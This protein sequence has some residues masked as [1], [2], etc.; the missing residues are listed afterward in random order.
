VAMT[1]TYHDY[2]NYVNR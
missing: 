2:D 1:M